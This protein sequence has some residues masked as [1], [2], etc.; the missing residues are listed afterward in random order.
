MALPL[1]TTQR[2]ARAEEGLALA[3]QAVPGA[4]RYGLIIGLP[5]VPLP[6]L[7]VVMKG[8]LRGFTIMGIPVRF[9]G[10]VDV[11]SPV[12]EDRQYSLIAYRGDGTIVPV[13]GVGYYPARQAPRDRDYHLLQPPALEAEPQPVPAPPMP[14]PEL[15]GSP[16][17][18]LDLF[19]DPAPV[20]TAPDATDVAPIGPSDALTS[21]P[22]S[23]PVSSFP[24]QDAAPVERRPQ[25]EFAAATAGPAQDTGLLDPGKEAATMPTLGATVETADVTD[26]VPEPS[27]AVAKTASSTQSTPLFASAVSADDTVHQPESEPAATVPVTVDRQDGETG[28]TGET[29]W[30]DAAAGRQVPDELETPP[31]ATATPTTPE[32]ATSE[33]RAGRADKD[34][35]GRESESRFAG[36]GK[37]QGGSVGAGEEGAGRTGRDDGVGVE[38]PAGNA[39][40]RPRELA[41]LLDEAELHLRWSDGDER[42]VARLLDQAAALDPTHSRLRE[43]QD[44][45]R[46]RQKEGAR[47]ATASVERLLAEARRSLDTGDDWLAVDLYAR[48]L[49]VQ[50]HNDEARQGAERARTRALWTARM[51]GSRR[52][53]KRLLRIGDEF[54]HA[55]DLALQSF[56][57]SFSLRPTVAALQGWLLALARDGQWENAAEAARQGVG[58]LR[59]CGRVEGS[60]TPA[61]ER[62]LTR[63][64]DEARAGAPGALA[65]VEDVVADLSAALEAVRLSA[66]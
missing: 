23:S 59:A 20:V 50:E 28:E 54:A 36:A 43:L 35:I 21:D 22:A 29:G 6:P 51:A 47:D 11:G 53:A 45:L 19:G 62:A 57:A 12:G 5:D 48:V 60:A 26:S 37:D 24:A 7:D 52:D 56:E 18:A 25:V 55:P 4:M 63:M 44:R 1:V 10:A 13:P 16:G 58:T 66:D 38:R 65:A 40:A 14:M 41:A 61:Q 8:A 33:D 2:H 49:A 32:Q 31:T 27:R 46:R 9:T 17:A 64:Q 15:A 42:E 39:P 3:W 30:S 34:R